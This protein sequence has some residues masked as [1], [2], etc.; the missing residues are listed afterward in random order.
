[1]EEQKEE[2]LNNAIELFSKYGIRAVTMDDLSREMAISK[3]T[4]YQHINN[5]EDLVQEAVMKIFGDVKSRLEGIMNMKGNAID[6][7]MEV[8]KGVCETVKH[9]DPG[10]QFQLQ[11][12]YPKVFQELDGKRKAMVTGLAQK[13]TRQGMQEGLY[14]PDLD[15]HLISNLYFSRVEF[16]KENE[17][18]SADTQTLEDSMR[19]ILEYHIHGIASEKGLQYL[20]KIKKHNSQ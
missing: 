6:Q 17:E 1:M 20:E 2:I 7:L 13:N 3:K 10:M 9:H 4:I 15:V 8:D 18:F 14:R 16:L 19:K 11:K 5:K 12:Y